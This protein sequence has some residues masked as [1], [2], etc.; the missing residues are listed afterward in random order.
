M[1][2]CNILHVHQGFFCFQPS[3]KNCQLRCTCNFYFPDR[4][5]FPFFSLHYHLHTPALSN[6]T[7]GIEITKEL[8]KYILI[9]T[10]PTGYASLKVKVS[11]YYT[12]NALQY[13]YIYH[14]SA[15]SLRSINTF[16]V[17]M[18]LF[19]A[20]PRNAV[21]LHACAVRQR[22]ANCSVVWTDL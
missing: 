15:A 19:H 22:N 9:Q 2:R 6:H 10:P 8:P 7:I 3:S 18:S 13:R 20:T 12:V 4:S 14:I 5:M 1:H 16:Q 17:K 21:T 11:S